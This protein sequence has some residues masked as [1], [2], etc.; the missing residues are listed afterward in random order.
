MST[1]ITIDDILLARAVLDAQPVPP[2]RCSWPD[3]HVIHMSL[4]HSDPAQSISVAACD[5]GWDHRIPWSRGTYDIQDQACEN[6]WLEI[7][8]RT[9]DVSDG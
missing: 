3:G 6:H 9:S 5:C 8:R 2:R 7:E 4:D 1:Q